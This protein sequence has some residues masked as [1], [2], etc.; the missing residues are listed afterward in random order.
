MADHGINEKKGEGLHTSE[1]NVGYDS[2]IVKN[3]S[4]AA[5]PGKIVTLIG[6]NG[7][8]KSTLMLLLD[9]LYE[10]PEESGSI[11]ISGKD[12]RRIPL[13][14]LSLRMV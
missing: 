1:L 13:P 2:G 9:R 3:I 10:L 12:I 7:S 14:V 4:L 6:P 5:A 11:R 8:G